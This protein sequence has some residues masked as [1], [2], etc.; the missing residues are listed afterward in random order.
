MLDA[1]ASSPLLAVFVVLALGAALGAV[2]LGP[3][4]LGAAGALFVGLA[5]GSLVPDVGP[6][7]ALVQTLG[8]ALFVYM[9]GLTAGQTFFSDLTR[10]APIMVCALVILGVLAVAVAF[11]AR[12]FGLSP[13]ITAGVYSGALTATPALAAANAAAGNTTASIGYA[14]GYPV[15]V[16]VAIGVVSL[17]VGRQ[18]PG[19]RDTEPLSDGDIYATSVTVLHA[20]PV[21]QVPG[22]AAQSLRMSYLRRQ[23]RTRVV[24]PGEEL[25][26]GDEV[27]FVGQRPVVERAIAC[28]GEELPRHLADDRA[29]VD[30][31]HFTLSN[32]DLAGRSVADLNLPGRFG[33]VM[34]RVRRGDHE[35]LAR[36]DLALELG[37]R[38]LVVVPRAELQSVA[39]FLGDSDRGV[40]S[41][42]ALSV[43]LGMALG[44]A[45]GLIEIPLPTGS[46]F[47][48]GAAAGPLIVGMIAGYLQRTG[49]VIWQIPQAANLSIRQL[50]LLIFLAA[51]GLSAGPSFAAFA[52]TADGAAAA[53]MGLV[54]V[55][56]TT[57]LLAMGGRLLGLSAPRT[58]GGIAGI[59]G[60]PAI[61]AHASALSDDDRIESGYAALF[62]LAMVA[63]IVLVH[64]IVAL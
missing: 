5:L 44:L 11:L 49:P 61:L 41:F 64:V 20:M 4:R 55:T 32:R 16:V 50:G 43:G 60:Q 17:V 39:R 48:L 53:L 19:S 18:W 52:F 13:E 24:A 21:R 27:L 22:Y 12:L 1:L 37:D 28:V 14:I 62:A 7:L 56:A 36:D 38:V 51:V 54:V 2:P 25:Q 58:A 6:E 15:G 9:V 42:S 8:L 10:Q 63:K 47:A 46:S 29:H 35:L 59:I 31:T 3:L 30:F 33:G 40:S 57:T 26:E 45:L 34:T 23:G